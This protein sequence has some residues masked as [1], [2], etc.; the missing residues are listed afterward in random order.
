MVNQLIKE[1]RIPMT[2]ANN[3]VL[4]LCQRLLLLRISPSEAL[5]SV[6]FLLRRPLLGR[7]AYYDFL[8]PVPAFWQYTVV[9]AWTV[10][11]G[12]G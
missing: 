10:L 11:M 6:G 8:D 7:E 1:N 5:G 3:S 9:F 12:T 2:V 4:Q